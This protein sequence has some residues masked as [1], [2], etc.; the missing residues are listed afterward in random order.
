MDDIAVKHSSASDSAT[1][2]AWLGLLM[3][4]GPVGLVAMDGSVLYLAMPKITTALMP[5]ADQALW[6][7]DIYGFIVGSLLV[8]FGNIGDRFGRLK[9]MMIGALIFGLGS[10][11]ASYSTSPEMLIGFRA[12]MG[13]GGATLLPSGLAIVSELFP[14]PKQ[15]AQAIGIFAA[16][17]AGGFAVGP[18]IGGLLLGKFAWGVVFLINIPIVVLFLIFAPILLKEVRD[19]GVGKIDLLSLVLSFVGMLLFTYSIKTAAAEGFSTEQMLTGAIGVFAMLWFIRRQ[20]VLDDP[21]LDLSLFKDRVF[22]VAILTGLLSLVVWSATG[23]LAGIYLQSVLG[24]PVLTAALVTIPGAVV[25]TVTCVITNKIVERTGRKYGLVLTHF[26]ISIGSFILLFTTTDNGVL[27]FIASTII[28]GVGYGLSFS[29]VADIAVSAAPPERAGAAAAIA[30]TSNEIGNAL[31]ITL[32]GSLAALTFR[33]SGP[34]EAGTLNETLDVEG[35]SIDTIA[36]AQN[37]YMEG[38][39]LALGAAGIM[40]LIVGILAIIWVPR[41]LPE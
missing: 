27:L 30:E 36:H 10:V 2:K 20:R 34:G 17:F 25:L 5:T 19:E 4:L 35:I 1:Q 7:L 13:L 8:A 6:I 33:I 26:L 28:A 29:L 23:Y 9:L 37:A 11:G 39:H 38:M 16:T 18:L 12:L 21:L 15:R 41:T 3:V 31:G 40:T 14:N 24:L 32:L 22:T